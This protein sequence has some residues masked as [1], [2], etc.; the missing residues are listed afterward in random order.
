ML[1]FEPKVHTRFTGEDGG[2]RSRGSRRPLRFAIASCAVAAIALASSGGA[3]AADWITTWAA[4]VQP[5]FTSDF[6]IKDGI[7]DLANQTVR[8]FVRTSV[9]GTQVR[10]V[11]SN[12]F[13]S[14][15]LVIG[16]THVALPSSGSGITAGSDTALTFAGQPSV[17]IPPGA[18][19]IS[20]PAKF[21]VKP[22]SGLAVS[23]FVPE[24]TTVGAMHWDAAQT[25]YISPPGN[26][27]GDTDMKTGSKMTSR[28]FLADVMVDASA[29]SRAVVLFGDSI[30]DG[31]CSTA[32]AN[33]R[34]PDVLAERL[35]SSAGGKVAV[36]NQGISGARVLTDQMG[37]NALAR[38]D[39]DVI[40]QPGVS[41]LVIMLGINDI[42][43][44]GTGL[45]P[46]ESDPTSA[47]I[48]AVH[49]QM[50]DRA[51]FQ[52][53]KVIGA[54]LTPFGDAFKGAAFEGYFTPEKEEMRQAVNAWIR[55]GGAYDGVIDFDKVVQNPD[56]PADIRKEFNCGD[57]LHPNDAGYKAMGESIDLGLLTGG[58]N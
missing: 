5:R 4:S 18:R 8:Q 55:T 29:D 58:A 24:K 56:K 27:A 16:A 42:G 47:A 45:A 41:A 23:I 48:I 34:W 46:K 38:F 35:Q 32:D 52:G 49:Q 15:P 39:R 11:L 43:W 1:K 14:A 36:V 40:A 2:A 28:V 44:P 7:P 17:T 20:D 3:S 26:F 10:V 12:E 50:I 53:I 30:T 54:T 9:G 51:H 13:G 6:A 33:R 31:A 25:A 19:V 22:L 57:N 37:Q 21:D